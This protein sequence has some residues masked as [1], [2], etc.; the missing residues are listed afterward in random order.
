VTVTIAP[1]GPASFDSSAGRVLPTYYPATLVP[2]Q[3][4]LIAV[5]GTGERSGVDVQVQRVLS[6]GVDGMIAMP[7]LDGVVIQVSLVSADPL[8]GNVNSNRPGQDGRFQFRGIA[9]GRYVVVATTVPAPPT[10]TF[11][12]GVP[13][14]PPP[15]PPRID[16]AQ[17]LWAR[18]EV[19][20]ESQSTTQISLSLQ[21]GR[22]IS[23]IVTFEM[24]KPPDLSR[25]RFTVT[26]NMATTGPMPYFGQAPTAQVGPD[27][28]F[29]LNGV[30]PG[31][32]VLRATGNIKSSM[33]NG[34]DTLD[35]PLEFTA[36]HDITGVVVTLTDRM[37]ELTG[38]ITDEAGR[39]GFA[40]TI[41]AAAADP[42]YWTPGSR[43][44]VTTRPDTSGRYTFRNLPPGDYLL[45]ALTELEPGRQ[46]DQELLRTL[47]GS[48]MRVTLG[49]GT[50]LTQSLRVGR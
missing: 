25:A 39:P 33:V 34:Q 26:A 29:T 18:T 4:A 3:A 41:V 2:S 22:S 14:P 11:I 10:P 43:R 16:D 8:F 20:V 12:N 21:P 6:G 45:A 44:I 46:F 15:Q 19:T 28:R 7:P 24:D 30:V 35:F 49:E 27:G 13:T 31:T 42:R 17:K 40:Y 37:T 48:S 23:G 1:P 32:Y 38:T 50:K 5:D 47:A 36:E 9:P